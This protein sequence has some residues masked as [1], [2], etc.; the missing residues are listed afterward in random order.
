MLYEVIT[1][2][3]L[4]EDF[5][6]DT[7]SVLAACDPRT[8]L[9]FLCSPNNP[10]GNSLDP[11]QVLRIITESNTIVVLDEAYID[12]SSIPGFS[13]KIADYPNLVILQTFS[14]AWGLAGIRLGMAI[15][16]QELIS[17]MQRV[18]YPYNINSLIV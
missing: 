17:L 4:R 2:I 18:K 15:A 13:R 8:K 1:E 10:T 6:L 11:D 14:K 7:A 12:F 9:I 3:P 16:G 5:S